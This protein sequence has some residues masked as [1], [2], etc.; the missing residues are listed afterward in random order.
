MDN[1]LFAQEGR[2]REQRTNHKFKELISGVSLEILLSVRDKRRTCFDTQ[3]IRAD[4]FNSHANDTFSSFESRFL[5]PLPLLLPFSFKRVSSLSSILLLFFLF[6]FLPYNTF[7][8]KRYRPSLECLL[9]F[10]KIIG[11]LLKTCREKSNKASMA[12][13]ATQKDKHLLRM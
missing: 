12:Y 8:L 6:F 4:P 5:L 13:V 11:Q 2:G 1:Y 10:S 9:Y 3:R 7:T